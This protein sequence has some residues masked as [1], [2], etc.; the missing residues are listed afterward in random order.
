MG[1][2]IFLLAYALWGAFRGRRRKLAEMLYR[3][4]RTAMAMI[5]GVGLFRW[6]G[7]ALSVVTGKYFS[8]SMGFVI[9]FVFP[10]VVVRV[11]KNTLQAWIDKRMGS[12]DGRL[13]AAMLGFWINL[14]ILGAMLLTLY[15]T[16]TG[17]IRH[18]LA[19]HSGLV[20]LMATFTG[21]GQ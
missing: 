2:D 13:W 3:L 14:L 4:L 8:D 20:R 7:S 6:I 11:F 16:R 1:I 5:T 18:F 15:L 9:A 19:S 12:D 21:G 10:L 17:G